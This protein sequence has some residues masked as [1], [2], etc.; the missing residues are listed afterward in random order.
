MNILMVGGNFDD[1][2]GRESSVINKLF[3]HLYA[4]ANSVFGRGGIYFI[5]INGG[6]YDTLESLF[7]PENHD[8]ILKQD[9]IFW[10]ANVPNDKEKIVREIKNINQNCILITSKANY[11]KK[12]GFQELVAR[13]LENKANLLMEIQKENDSYNFS[14][15]DPL[16]N[17]YC[18][19]KQ[20]LDVVAMAMIK[21]IK[22]L[23]SFTRVGSRQIESNLCNP[24]FIDLIKICGERFH[25]LIHGAN[26][27]RYLGNASFRCEH[28]F[29]SFRGG[30]SIYVTRR[31]VDKRGINFDSFVKTSMG[32]KGEVV[33]IGSHKPSVDTPIQQRLYGYYTEI[34][35]MIHSHVYVKGAPFTR[36]K[37]PCGAIEEVAEITSVFPWHDKNSFAINLKGHGSLI[38]GSCVDDLIF[39]ASQF[40]ARPQ[41]EE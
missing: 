25:E 22:E 41:W 4:H 19:N 11:D 8:S 1:N 31:N 13:A 33:Y 7:H 27:E 6:H 34:N 30:E 37:V 39:Y 35:Y 29:P 21:R 23:R 18:K 40:I 2:G 10:F 15:I 12:Y 36:H 9:V 5:L 28:G 17:C 38:A 14:V 3:S 26:T 20:D 24:E 32:D 16:G